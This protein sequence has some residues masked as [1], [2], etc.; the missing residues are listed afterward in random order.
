MQANL[1]VFETLQNVANATCNTSCPSI[2]N[3]GIE[4]QV[5][6]IDTKIAEANRKIRKLRKALKDA[7]NDAFLA[8]TFPKHIAETKGNIKQWE[9]DKAKLVETKNDPAFDPT[10]EDALYP[11]D[12][13]VGTIQAPAKP[14]PK[15]PNTPH[16]NNEITFE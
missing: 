8:D 5:R 12:Q 7:P 1:S 11:E 10:H 6:G 15:T 14:A 16:S 13:P 3:M 2:L 9:T 4:D